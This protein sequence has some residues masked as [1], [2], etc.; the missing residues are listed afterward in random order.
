M[1][2]IRL[3]KDEKILM[4]TDDA[5]R[6][7]GKDEIDIDE[8]YLTNKHII[9][10]YE[11]S[12]GIFSKA[13]TIVEKI[14]L[15]SISVVN[16]V[17]QVDQVNDEDYGKSLQIKY[18]NGDRD[19]FEINVSP[20]KQYPL[21]K[22]AIVD[23]VLKAAKPIDSQT[24]KYV[25]CTNCGE[26]IGVADKFCSACGAPTNNEP[27][28]SSIT[29]NKE[30]EQDAK[31]DV[32]GKSF[33]EESGKHRLTIAEKTISLRKSYIIS[34]NSGNAIYTAKSEGL[35]K[36]PEIGVYKQDKRI[37]RVAK[38]LFA[39]PVLGNPTYTIHWDDKR[40]AS[41]L[42]RF[43]L[44]LKFEIPENGWKFDIGVTKSTVYDSNGA[45]AVQ[46]QYVMSTK[47]PSFIVEYS[48]KENEAP[49]ILFALVA[50]M[51]CHMG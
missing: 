47:K 2:T 34:D 18:T 30:V 16:G 23:A 35:P 15:T 48:N 32:S 51:A 42:Q 50:I 49:A 40:V 7:D 12:G 3:D 37:G 29:E 24:R 38:E 27:A 10:A 6:Y 22:A 41:L 11:K 21:W 43:A 5:G 45:V 44:K 33:F 46:I 17:V 14:P 9:Y 19:L 39:N 4:Q 8:L 1:A 26:K 25:F 36:M 20:K 28:V 31:E 13:E